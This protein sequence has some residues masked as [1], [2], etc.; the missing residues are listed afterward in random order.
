MKQIMCF[1]AVLC[2]V[3]VTTQAE[4]TCFPVTKVQKV[5]SKFD[6]LKP[7]HL[8]TLETRLTASFVDPSIGLDK[9]VLFSKIGSKRD[10]FTVTEGGKILEFQSKTQSLPETAE[11]C[12]LSNADN[13]IG[14]GMGTDVVFKNKSGRFSIAEL[15]D[16]IKDGKAH[17]KVM[18]PGPMAMF[19]PKMTHVMVAYDPIETP[20]D[21]RAVVDGQTVTNLPIEVFGGAHV[22][23]VAALEEMG[24]ESLY[25]HGSN[26]ELSPVPS[27]K[28]MKS[29]GFGPDEDATDKVAKG[30]D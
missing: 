28:K 17:Y 9:M 14:L 29:L 6:K 25:V 22:I 23:S 11:I 21:I 18:L 24:V 3:S 12:G 15:K 13:K 26:F 27:I 19:V 2:C 7:E 20:S 30:K 4:E 1:L 8:D 10:D 5:Y 16:G